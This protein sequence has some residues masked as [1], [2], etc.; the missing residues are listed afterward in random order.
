[1]KIAL[2]FSGQPR[3]IEKCYPNILKNILEPNGMPDIYVHTWFPEPHPKGH[4]ILDN[5]IGDKDGIENI[6]K[7]YNPKRILVEKPIQFET[8][9]EESNIYSQYQYITQSMFYSIKESMRHLMADIDIIC[10]IRFDDIFHQP[11]KF[12]EHTV[13][14]I[15]LKR[16]ISGRLNDHF[17]FG[18]TNL[19][20]H[21]ANSYF[22]IKEYAKLHNKITPEDVLEYTLQQNNCP[23]TS[24]NWG[25]ETVRQ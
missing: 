12:V 8:L 23:I 13:N 16:E 24:H 1:M 25:W 21:Y 20:T 7:L 19:M 6:I 2:C 5:H 3:F 15:Y 17:A 10:R 18:P 4:R 22:H 9:L 11:I 14:S